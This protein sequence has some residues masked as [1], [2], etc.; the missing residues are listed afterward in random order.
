MAHMVEAGLLI[1]EAIQH[2]NLVAQL[3]KIRDHGRAKIAGATGDKNI[4]THRHIPL[5]L[6]DEHCPIALAYQQGRCPMIVLGQSYI[7]K[8]PREFD[9]K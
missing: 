3:N 4:V 6:I 2:R 1:H 5:L 9:S 8:S 7:D